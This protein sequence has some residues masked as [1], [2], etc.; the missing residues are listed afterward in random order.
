MR[1][2]TGNVSGAWAEMEAVTN[3]LCNKLVDKKK[4]LQAVLRT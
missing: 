2:F 1:L 4:L 3:S